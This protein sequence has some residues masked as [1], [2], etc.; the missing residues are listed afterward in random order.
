M[1]TVRPAFIYRPIFITDN[2]MKY[3]KTKIDASSNGRNVEFKFPIEW[4]LARREA[5]VTIGNDDVILHEGDVLSVIITSEEINPINIEITP[6]FDAMRLDAVEIIDPCHV[7]DTNKEVL[8]FMGTDYIVCEKVSNPKR[9]SIVDNMKNF[10][11]TLNRDVDMLNRYI[12]I[13]KKSRYMYMILYWTLFL[14]FMYMAMI[15]DFPWRYVY[16]AL[17]LILMVVTMYAT[18]I[19]GSFGLRK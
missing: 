15:T 10:D 18:Y 5:I 4:N 16:I 14:F 9:E 8:S 17:A 2:I 13:Y 7:V 19:F 3:K 11:D 1:E 12:C 6:N